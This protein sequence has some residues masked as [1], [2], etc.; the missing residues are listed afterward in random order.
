[1]TLLKNIIRHITKF[2]VPNYL[3][4]NDPNPFVSILLF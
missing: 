1:M 4:E 3:D 2:M